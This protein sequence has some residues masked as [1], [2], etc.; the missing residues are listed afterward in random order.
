M[1]SR[2]RHPIRRSSPSRPTSSISAS[3]GSQAPE[4]TATA[5]RQGGLCL[6][7]PTS[8]VSTHMLAPSPGTGHGEHYRHHYAAN[9]VAPFGRESGGLITPRI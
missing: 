6:P 3:P 7:L 8:Q 5:R 9:P 4:R 1:R 2:R